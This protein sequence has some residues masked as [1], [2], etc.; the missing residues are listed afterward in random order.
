VSDD[1][2]YEALG[3]GPASAVADP[4]LATLWEL[5]YT[6]ACREGFKYALKAALRFGHNYIGTEHLLI[7][8]A[9]GDGAVPLAFSKIGLQADLIENAVAVE[10]ADTLLQL[11]R[12]AG[13]SPKA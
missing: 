13:E 1:Q 12:Q 8:V 10:L 9:A 6:Q 5:Q 2:L 3:V 11:R 4:D 7:G